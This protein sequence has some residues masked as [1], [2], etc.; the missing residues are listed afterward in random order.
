MRRLALETLAFIVALL[1]FLSFALV[2]YLPFLL[3]AS[4]ED[5]LHKETFF[6]EAPKQ[7]GISRRELSS[8]RLTDQSRNRRG[9]FAPQDQPEGGI[10]S[11]DVLN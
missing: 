1:G 7:L 3:E 5:R 2:V 10:P 6:E 9:E 4:Q 8:A 11:G